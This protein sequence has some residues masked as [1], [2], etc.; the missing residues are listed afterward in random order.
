MTIAEREARHTAL[1]REAAA[2]SITLLADPSSILPLPPDAR[3]ALFGPGA[4]HT[5]AYGAGSGDVQGRPV[6]SIDAGLRAAGLT[7]TSDTWLDRMDAHSEAEHQAWSDRMDASV[8]DAGPDFM[9]AVRIAL[10]NR[11]TPATDLAIEAA[12]L[13]ACD[14]ATVVYVL[15]R[16]S[17]EGADRTETPGDYLLSDVE[18]ANLRALA[19]TG[20]PLVLLLNCGGPVDL[21]IVDELGD[22]AVMFVGHPG[23]Q[24]GPAVAD[25]LTG[26]VNP[27]GRLASTWTR[28]LD[29]HLS[30]PVFS[31]RADPRVQPY[32]EGLLLGY[33]GVDAR[34]IEPRYAFGHGLSYTTFAFAAAAPERADDRVRVGVRVTNTGRRAGET[35]VQ[36]YAASPH[37]GADVRRLVAFARTPR[38]EPGATTAVELEFPLER[39]S[40][41]RT[42]DSASVVAAGAH[43]LELGASSR[44]TRRVGVVEV[45][46]ELVTRRSAGAYPDLPSDWPQV[47]GAPLSVREL[48]ELVVGG[49]TTAPRHRVVAGAA[50]TTTSAL[51][52]SRGLANVLL[53]DGPAGFNVVAELVELPDGTVKGTTTYPHFDFPAMRAMMAGFFADRDAGTLIER[54]PTCWPCQTLLAS[55]WDPDLLQ[56][57]GDAIG[58]EATEFGVTVWL[59]PG[60]NLHRNPLGGRGFEYYSEDPVLTGLLAAA[61]TRGVQSHP[62]VGVSIK[63]FVA[64]DSEDDRLHSTSD[65]D[66]RTLR[67]LHLRA[68]EIA[69]TE[70]SPR[71]LMGSYNLVNGTYVVNS[72]RLLT[73][74]LRHEWGYDGLVMTDWG[75]VGP[76]EADPIEAIRAGVD[77]IMPGE[78]SQV[79]VIEAAAND[80]RLP[81][82][83]LAR[84]ASRV[85]ALVG[86]GLAAVEAGGRA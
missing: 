39:L 62:G 32:V 3:V 67:E 6:V 63:H 18:L 64:N 68:F 10:D 72:R 23:V 75:A 71:T 34:G 83:D 61:V 20:R 17:G 77:L 24:S 73:D 76:N 65:V 54:Y 84:A 45:D 86:E 43:V 49:G 8:G 19:A 46:R 80:G 27:A 15:T 21:S 78:P 5:S 28:A 4:R 7:I 29:D 33:R 12:D 11:P 51:L 55:S 50:G 48:A 37:D 57:V 47:D 44:T 31:S 40:W 13:A 35:V 69:L 79:D 41:F 36:L 9:S 14:D 58:A 16:R 70:S 74:V 42:T 22:V 30:T 66:E 81:A 52:E 25:V 60:A 59:A 82:A 53:A 38:I 56:R 2:R 26:A 85:L 1:A